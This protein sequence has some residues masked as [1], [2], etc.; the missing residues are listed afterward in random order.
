[1]C[2]LKT[3][4]TAYDFDLEKIKDLLGNKESEKSAV[5]SL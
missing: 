5:G 1:M 3:W 4:C 2:E